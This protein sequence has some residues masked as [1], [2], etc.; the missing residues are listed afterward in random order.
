[1]VLDGP[2][3]GLTVLDAGEKAWV[4]DNPWAGRPRVKVATSV[5]AARL[6]ALI[7]ERLML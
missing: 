4:G 5:D 7:K 1:M 2:A 6:V 3:K